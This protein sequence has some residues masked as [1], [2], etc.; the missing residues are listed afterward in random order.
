MAEAT[1]G[2][3]FECLA[4]IHSRIEFYR[5]CLDWWRY[6]TRRERIA[7]LGLARIFQSKRDDVQQIQCQLIQGQS[8]ARFQFQLNLAKRHTGIPGSDCSLIDT[9]FRLASSRKTQHA[10]IAPEFRGKNRA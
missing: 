6:V 1:P 4:D 8:A 7:T 10:D 5:A 3:G 9:K 2:N